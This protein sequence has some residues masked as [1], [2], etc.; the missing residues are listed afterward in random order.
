MNTKWNKLNMPFCTQQFFKIIYLIIN[1]LSEWEPI[2][3]CDALE[4]LGPFFSSSFVRCYAVSR[5]Q[6]AKFENVLLYLPQLVQALRYE[7]DERESNER[8]STNTMNLGV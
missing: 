5:L 3:A 8:R 2:D 6:W 4:L 7:S 1:Y